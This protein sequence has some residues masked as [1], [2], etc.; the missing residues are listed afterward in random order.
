MRA[1]L[2]LESD[3][4]LGNVSNYGAGMTVR[5]A[6]FSGRVVH[7]DDSRLQVAA[8]QRRQRMGDRGRL[9]PAGLAW[10]GLALAAVAYVPPA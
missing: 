2:Y 3:S 1:S 10:T 5:L 9:I 7:F 6:R 4:S 8:I